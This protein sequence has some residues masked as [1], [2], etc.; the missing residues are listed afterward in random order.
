MENY[1]CELGEIRKLEDLK[2]MKLSGNHSKFQMNLSDHIMSRLNVQRRYEVRLPSRE[3]WEEDSIITAGFDSVWYTD[4]LR[5]NE[6]VGLGIFNNHFTKFLSLGK[7]MTVYQAEVLAITTCVEELLDQNMSG[8]KILI[9]SDSQSVLKALS[10]DEIKSAVIYDCCRKIN[11]LAVHNE[12]VLTWVPGHTN[13][14]GN[15]RA[16]ALAKQ[17]AKQKF[18]GPEPHTGLS[19]GVVRHAKKEWINDKFIYGW[20]KVPRL[21]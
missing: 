10:K 11:E 14:K 5:T 16:D 2:L 8:N 9:C 20:Y 21:R 13:I 12:V 4:G 15:E 17:G 19:L 1:R 18:C 3:D 7:E 6:G